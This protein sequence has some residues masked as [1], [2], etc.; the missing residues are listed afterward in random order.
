ME[1]GMTDDKNKTFEITAHEIVEHTYLVT[2]ETIE[3][4]VEKV[5]EEEV[6][7]AHSE[8]VMVMIDEA[9]EIKYVN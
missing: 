6:S 7:I 2:A 8:S 3:E 1:K 5:Q 9:K 4:A